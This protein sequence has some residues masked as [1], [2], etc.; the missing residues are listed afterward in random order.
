[1]TAIALAISGTLFF[2]SN[3]PKYLKA[4]ISART[5]DDLRLG[6]MAFCILLLVSYLMKVALNATAEVN[7][8][9]KIVLENTDAMNELSKSVNVAIGEL[10]NY[11]ASL[12]NI[13]I[14]SHPL[15]AGKVTQTITTFTSFEP[16]EAKV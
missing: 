16:N 7:T 14:E 15:P 10:V 4:V 3:E 2:Q 13:T 8:L 1:M 5:F 6:L 12:T 11:R 9:E